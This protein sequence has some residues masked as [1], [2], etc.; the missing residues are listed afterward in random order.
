MINKIIESF[1]YIKISDL[2]APFIFIIIL[3]FSLIL[4][5]FNIVFDRHIWLVN[6]EK[7]TARDNGYY[8]FKYMRSEH[9]SFRCYYVI[10]K[11]CN[12]Y[13]KVK[14]LGN[15]IQFG[16]IKHWL[17]YMASEY[18]IS[19]Q[20]GANPN[21]VLFYFIHIYLRLYNNRV[22]LQHGITI[23]NG[24]WLH[25]KNTRFRYFICGAKREYDFIINNFGYPKKNVILTGFSRW[26]N[27]IENITEDKTILI[28]PTWRSWLGREMNNLQKNI[29]FKET[30][31]FKYWNGL[32]NDDNFIKYIE[33]NN[34]QVYFYPHNN[35][36]K[37]L[38]LFNS[39]SKNISFINSNTDIQYMLRKSS[40]MITD[41]SS[42]SLDF[43]YM[44]KPVIY[45]QFDEKEYREKQYKDGYYS[46]VND[47]YGPVCNNL[48][49]LVNEIIKI[50]Q[51]GLNIKYE[52]RMNEFFELHDKNNCERIYNAISNN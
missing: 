36:Q 48:E 47:G 21:T 45:Y 26:D 2:F 31:Y 30:N 19:N 5:L 32:L 14:D 39:K 18:N 16:S 25:Y 52:K 9:K 37:F 35:M 34:Y 49:D 43:G 44:K 10:D 51:K 33:K 27:L 28:M 8:F 11:K 7:N 17:Y 22:F 12:D 42:V 13:N 3:P 41:Y 29:N 1:K 20:K 46:Y 15:I 4:K 6:E 40:I 50:S 24:E 23:N 38:Y